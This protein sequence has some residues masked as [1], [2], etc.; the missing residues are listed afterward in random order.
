MADIVYHNTEI[1]V[2]F[3]LE[4]VRDV[5]SSLED[6]IETRCKRSL[7]NFMVPRGIESVEYVDDEQVYFSGFEGWYAMKYRAPLTVES[8][9]I[10]LQSE[11]W[12][13]FGRDTLDA[14]DVDAIRDGDLDHGYWNTWVETRT[15]MADV[16]RYAGSEGSEVKHDGTT[17][18]VITVNRD[19]CGED[20]ITYV[21]LR[22][23]VTDSVRNYRIPRDHP[24]DMDMPYGYFVCRGELYFCD[25]IAETCVTYH[26]PSYMT[27]RE[28][29]HP[30]VC[31]D[32]VYGYGYAAGVHE[33]HI[34]VYQVKA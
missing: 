32:M 31:T 29:M 4:L 14:E 30:G 12:L 10:V 7:Q 2:S 3:T 27:T 8:Q 19:G 9:E 21:T 15:G 26:V 1:P 5:P 16:L 22:N 17:P 23:T 13:Y 11:D 33:G 34:R 25:R 24:S 20:M 18:Y 6:D 28:E